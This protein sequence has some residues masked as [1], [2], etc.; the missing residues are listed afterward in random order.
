MRDCTRET[1]TDGLPVP[2]AHNIETDVE[3]R[4]AIG[5]LSCNAKSAAERLDTYLRL[6]DMERRAAEGKAALASEFEALA[7]SLG[8]TIRFGIRPVLPKGTTWDHAP[9]GSSRTVA[10]HPSS[11]SCDNLWEYR[12]GDRKKMVAWAKD[13]ISAVLKTG[14][15]TPKFFLIEPHESSGSLWASVAKETQA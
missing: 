6:H 13:G 4:A 1:S 7:Q 2:H 10:G 5:Y 12:D 8:V 14:G 9:F 3:W 15:A 11:F